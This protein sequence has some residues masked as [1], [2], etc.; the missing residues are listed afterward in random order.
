MEYRPVVGSASKV[1]LRRRQRQYRLAAEC[2]TL[3]GICVAQ[4]NKRSANLRLE[5]SVA[6][7]RRYRVAPSRY[8]AHTSRRPLCGRKHLFVLFMFCYGIAAPLDRNEAQTTSV[9]VDSAHGQISDEH[10]HFY[11]RVALAYLTTRVSSGRTWSCKLLRLASQLGLELPQWLL[12]IVAHVRLRGESLA[13]RISQLR[14][15]PAL[16]MRKCAE[17]GNCARPC[18]PRMVRPC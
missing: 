5:T 17:A 11:R 15:H 4:S 6:A 18:E 13:R 7:A 2:S 10:R 14:R 3:R 9:R 8:S 1:C 16:S 12:E